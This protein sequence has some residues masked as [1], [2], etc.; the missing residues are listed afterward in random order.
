MKLVD[1]VLVNPADASNSAKLRNVLHNAISSWNSGG[2]GNLH[3]KENE[4]T[5]PSKELPFMARTYENLI[6]LVEVNDRSGVQAFLADRVPVDNRVVAAAAKTGDLVLVNMLLAEMSDYE[7]HQGA[8]EPILSVLGT[9][10]FEMLKALTKL[11]TFNPQWVSVEGKTWAELA[12][13]MAGPMYKQEMEHLDRLLRRSMPVSEAQPKQRFE[14]PEDLTPRSRGA[15]AADWVSDT[16]AYI[17]TPTE[18][19]FTPNMNMKLEDFIEDVM[20]TSTYD[21]IPTSRQ[22]REIHDSVKRTVN[23]T[24][25]KRGEECDWGMR[26]LVA[27]R[28][29]RV[30]KELAAQE[31][32]NQSKLQTRSSRDSKGR[33]TVV[34]HKPSGPIP[35]EGPGRPRPRKSADYD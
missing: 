6:K 22:V 9:S 10:H 15:T 35:E 20:S 30:A 24:M 32:L 14:R 21:E 16:T 4:P 25:V 19:I 17:S 34:V 5:A 18:S 3:E 11:E 29:E 1:R 7:R 13:Q 27:K 8:Q 31:Q 12:Q 33:P 28:K 2:D 26:R 23:K